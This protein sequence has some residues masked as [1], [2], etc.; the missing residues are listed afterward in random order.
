MEFGLGKIRRALAYL[1]FSLISLSAIDS[2]ASWDRYQIIM[3]KNPFGRLG[4]AE[5]VTIPE[6]AKDYRLCSLAEIVRGSETNLYAGFAR[7]S[8]NVKSIT[9]SF[10]Q[11]FIKQGELT[12]EGLQVTDIDVRNE[13]AKLW[14]NGE[15]ALMNVQS[16]PIPTNSLLGNNSLMQGQSGAKNPWAEFYQR[17]QQR[18][19]QDGSQSSQNPI[20]I[21]VSQDGKI[22]R[23]SLGNLSSEQRQQIQGAVQE[24]RLNRQTQVIQNMQNPDVQVQ[25]DNSSVQNNKHSH[26]KKSRQN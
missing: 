20:T 5:P 8:F 6:F 16:L 26:S 14:R 24:Y 9:N 21:Q 25:Q 7:N 12:E 18:H 22:N 3:D 2:K 15:S 1:A 4:P 10:D 17:Y 13:S 11:V 19:S 23:D